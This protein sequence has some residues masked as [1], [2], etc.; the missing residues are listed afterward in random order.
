MKSLSLVI[1]AMMFMHAVPASAGACRPIEY[2]ELK[3]TATE[4]VVERY[5]RYRAL[6]YVEDAYYL[7]LLEINEKRLRLYRKPGLSDGTAKDLERD[8]ADGKAERE[9]T[10]ASMDGCIDQQAKM[11]TVLKSRGLDEPNCPERY[12]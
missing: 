5:C 12:R 2:A 3:D 11:Q 7:K 10:L 1:A 6:F 9:A 8:L 4:I